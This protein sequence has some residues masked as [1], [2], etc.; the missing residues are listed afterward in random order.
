MHNVTAK[1][2]CDHVSVR[3]KVGDFRNIGLKEW[4]MRLITGKNNVKNLWAV[5]DLSFEL[6][7]G[8]ILGVIGSNGAGK[9]TLLKAVSNVMKPA[10]GRITRVGKVAAFLELS[11][12]FD[13]DL[14]VKENTY[15]RGAMIGYSREF[16]DRVYD[17]IIEFAELKEFE[18]LAFRQL[19][20]GMRSRLAFAL[21]SIVEPDILILDEVLSVGDGAF[22]KKSEAKMRE[23]MGKGAITIFVSH[24]INQI[25]S[26]CNKA[27]WMD[28]GRL[29]EFSNDV[30]GCCERYEKFLSEKVKG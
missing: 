25:R 27:L 18:N 21:A 5:S 10:K 2:I 17:S 20:S 9:S 1:I 15:L 3:Y 28:K 11:S 7:D 19:S 26:F 6:N 8:D 23:L 14:T 22:R 24:S 16:M 4:V 29:V 13:G 30:K 12:G